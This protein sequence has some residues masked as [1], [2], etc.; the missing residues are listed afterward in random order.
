MKQEIK[1]SHIVL[2]ALTSS[3]IETPYFGIQNTE[4]DIETLIAALIEV[5]QHKSLYT[6]EPVPKHETY[7]PLHDL[8]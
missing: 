2:A 8:D 5:A 1:K 7:E 6:Y 4:Q 3:D